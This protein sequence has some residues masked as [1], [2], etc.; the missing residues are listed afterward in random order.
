MHQYYHFLVIKQNHCSSY[1]NNKLWPDLLPKRKN[2][3]YKFTRCERLLDLFGECLEEA[4]MYIPRKFRNGKTYVASQ[5]KS[6]IV[7]KN[8]I[9][10]LQSECEILKLRKNSFLE[11]AWTCA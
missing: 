9:N 2:F 8:D 6:N 10:N 11:N 3:V 7:K 1:S 4:P 5:E